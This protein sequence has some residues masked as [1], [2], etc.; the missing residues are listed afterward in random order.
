MGAGI[1]DIICKSGAG[2]NRATSGSGE[3]KGGWEKQE[4]GVVLKRTQIITLKWDV[5]VA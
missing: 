4:N 1:G 5:W 2:E 3:L